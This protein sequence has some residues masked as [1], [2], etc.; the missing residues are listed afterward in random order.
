M[1]LVSITNQKVIGTGNGFLQIGTTTLNLRDCGS[2][3]GNTTETTVREV[4]QLFD[5]QPQV[6]VWEE[7]QKETARISCT[8]KEKSFRMVCNQMGF[9]Y[10]TKVDETRIAQADITVTGEIKPLFLD[11]W[12]H[13]YGKNVK[14][15]PVPVVTTNDPTPVSLSEGTDYVIDYDKGYIRKVIGGSLNDGDEILINYTYTRGSTVGMHLG[16]E[17]TKEQFMVRFVYE[18]RYGG[19]DITEYAKAYPAPEL[20]QTYNQ[21][22]WNNREIAF[23]AVGD[24]TK[25]EGQRLRIQWKEEPKV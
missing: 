7:V 3:E 22:A 9:D 14:A 12:A 10:D 17:Q 5:G 13:L 19:R 15:S 1:G 6:L 21:S 11:N 23:D 2:L 4:L 8:L 24:M 18:D 25:A 20:V 16:G